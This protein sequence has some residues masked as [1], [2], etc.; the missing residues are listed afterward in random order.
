MGV[1]ICIML[2]DQ[3]RFEDLLRM[4]QSSEVELREGFQKLQACQVD[5]KHERLTLLAD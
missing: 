1:Y 5:G 2:C 4:V 3:Y